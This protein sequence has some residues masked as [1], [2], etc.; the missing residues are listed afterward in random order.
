LDKRKS[1]KRR[2][3]GA[4]SGGE[5]RS[6]EE[7]EK[8]EERK[9]ML[10][11]NQSMYVDESDDEEEVEEV[12][13]EEK[14]GRDEKRVDPPPGIERTQMKEEKE[15]RGER[16]ESRG[17]TVSG[18][19]FV[20]LADLPPDQE[21]DL[22]LKKGDVI[23]I[24]ETRS[25]GWWI[26][27][28]EGKERGLVP[29]TFLAHLSRDD[30]M[31]ERREEEKTNRLM[32]REE[33][34][35]VIQ[36]PQP[37]PLQLET[38]RTSRTERSTVPRR[39][40]SLGE[41]FMY[42]KHVSLSCHLTPRLSESNLSFHDLFW[43][44]KQDMLRKRHVR[45]SKLVRLVRIEKMNRL[46]EGG[47]LVRIC[48]FDRSSKTGRQIVSNV[49]TIRAKCGR[50]DWTFTEKRE[51][52]GDGLSFGEFVLRS[53]YRL[54]RVNMLIQVSTLEKTTNGELEEKA[55]GLIELPLLDDTGNILLTNK[56]YAESLKEVSLF[57]D[58]HPGV[59]SSLR[60]IVLKVRDP[61]REM[62]HY[63]D[64]MPDILVL[65]PLHLSPIFYFRRH[66]GRVLIRDRNSPFSAEL[67]NDL[68]LA[69]FPTSCDDA[70]LLDMMA[71][72][73]VGTEKTLA[74]LNSEDITTQFHQLFS[75][76]CLLTLARPHI[77]PFSWLANP[78]KADK[79][80]KEMKALASALGAKTTV[81]TML[82]TEKCQPLRPLFFSFDLFGEHAID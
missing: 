32:G 23:S 37:E 13:R 67:I 16:E 57:D 40:S 25:D 33:T 42:D 11:S 50:S 76:L 65:S 10:R 54:S 4:T 75:S 34:S 82:L 64:S 7:S 77:T 51:K 70:D 6:D 78:V 9:K 48:L 18:N 20:V 61:P 46:G 28:N 30:V 31:R 59:A 38:Q 27:E 39:Y 53:N 22:P 1:T 72:V 69:I 73:W 60:K 8:E 17:R 26:G 35:Q 43:N 52:N 74:N 14:K 44:H 49:H 3:K 45:V 36:R 62:T 55:V 68:T 56:S 79:R 80:W 81:T 2:L 66:A 63:I 47:G 5:V 71:R 19:L 24:V 21:G 29:R 15:E 12:K 58:L 41:A